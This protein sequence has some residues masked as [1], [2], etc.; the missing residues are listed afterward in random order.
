MDKD[1]KRICLKAGFEDN[2]GFIYPEHQYVRDGT[3]TF[4]LMLDFLASQTK[5]SAQLF[6]SLPK[7]WT[8]KIKIPLTSQMKVDNILNKIKLQYEKHGKVVDTD[9]DGLKI[10]GKDFWFIVRKSGTEPVI[11][12][13][14]EAKDKKT[15]D[16]TLEELKKLV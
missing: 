5:S 14:V 11:R 4:A 1:W 13:S 10:A 7:Y 2:G 9:H 3:M 6:D 15:L 8:E 16:V 12:I